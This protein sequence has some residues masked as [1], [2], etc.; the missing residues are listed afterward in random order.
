MAKCC[1]RLALIATSIPQDV[2][3]QSSQSPPEGAVLTLEAPGMDKLQVQRTKSD[4]S[5]TRSC[6]TTYEHCAMSPL[7]NLQMK[8]FMKAFDLVC[9]RFL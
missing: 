5:T 2:L 9:C 4:D 8:P 3:K 1:C 6:L 7:S